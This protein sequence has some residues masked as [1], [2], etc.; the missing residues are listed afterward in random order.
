MD[1]KMINEIIENVI[2]QLQAEGLI[3]VKPTTPLVINADAPGIST[4]SKAQTSDQKTVEINLA[5]PTAPG[6]RS[7]PRVDH[8]QNPAALTELVAS[9][10]ARIGVGRAGPRYKTASLLLFQGDH[11]VT[12][13]A[14][15]RDVDQSLLDELGI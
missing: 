1:E 7:L 4:Q 5:D 12:Q 15:Y 10:P 9:T 2:Q 11:A 8:A 14:L 6:L 13:D 3:S